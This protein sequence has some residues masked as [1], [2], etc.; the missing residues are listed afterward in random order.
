MWPLPS[1]SLKLKGQPC[2]PLKIVCKYCTGQINVIS[3]N[4]N[5][6]WRLKDVFKAIRIRE[7]IWSK[8]GVSSVFKQ[9]FFFL[10]NFVCGVREVIFQRLLALF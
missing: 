4:Q 3:H 1:L 2:P 8:L 6:G 10:V 9:T 5:F 7:R